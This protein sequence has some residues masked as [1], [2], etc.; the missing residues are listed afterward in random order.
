MS[1]HT[2]FGCCFF[3]WGEG[4]GWFFLIHIIFS[5]AAHI[6]LNIIFL[7]FTDTFLNFK[8]LL[9]GVLTVCLS[10]HLYQSGAVAFPRYYC[11]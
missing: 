9:F 4:V 7:I 11:G 5:C 3:F 10:S 8:T 2:R 6:E 1:L